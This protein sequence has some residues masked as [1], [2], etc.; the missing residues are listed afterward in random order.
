MNFHR[1]LLVT[2]TIGILKLCLVRGLTATLESQ[3]SGRGPLSNCTGPFTIGTTG[4]TCLAVDSVLLSECITRCMSS[5]CCR[6]GG[7]QQ[8]KCVFSSRQDNSLHFIKTVPAHVQQCHEG[9]YGINLI[10]LFQMLIT[11]LRV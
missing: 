8:G 9:E 2:C 3:C 5:H 6:A 10:K 7:V 4:Q 11:S 1:G